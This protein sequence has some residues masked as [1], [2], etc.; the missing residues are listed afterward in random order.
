MG[1]AHAAVA[2]RRNGT[3]ANVVYRSGDAVEVLGEL[4]GTELWL[5]VEV[6]DGGPCTFAW[7]NAGGEWKKAAASFQAQPGKWIGAKVGL[8]CISASDKTSVGFGDFDYF[9]FAAL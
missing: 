8:Y 7:Q 1:N 9:R 3:G 6:A 2:V 5:A 4:V